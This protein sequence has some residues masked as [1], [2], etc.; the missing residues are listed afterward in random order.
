[1]NQPQ[2]ERGTGAGTYVIT[3]II[4]FAIGFGSA[5]LVYNKK[6]DT[7]TTKKTDSVSTTTGSTSR[8]GDTTGTPS[9]LGTTSTSNSLKVNDQAAGA[10]VEVSSVTLKEPAWIVIRETDPESDEPG[11]ILGAQ[12][13]DLGT[14]P[15]TVELLRGTLPG[16]TYFAFVYSDNGDHAFDP[17]IDLPLKDT[18][19]AM[20]M[21]TFKAQ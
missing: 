4:A 6:T 15:G 2:E 9:T 13:F 1:M 12:L 19:G 18:N 11:R 17:K 21:T 3:A 20:I 8:T 16:K 14:N 7:T 5:W 10:M